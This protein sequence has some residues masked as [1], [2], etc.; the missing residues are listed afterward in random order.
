MLGSRTLSDQST[1]KTRRRLVLFSRNAPT[2]RRQAVHRAPRPP[3]IPAPAGAPTC[4]NA[5]RVRMPRRL[6][7]KNF[8]R[9]A[10]HGSILAPRSDSAEA[11]LQNKRNRPTIAING[12]VFSRRLSR[13]PFACPRRQVE[14]PNGAVNLASTRSPKPSKLCFRRLD[15]CFESAPSGA[16]AP[17]LKTRLQPIPFLLNQLKARDIQ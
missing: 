12:R 13:R 1:K 11:P 6:L 2:C 5:K 14:Q 8:K 10:D 16:I 3:P 4:D 9:L 15:D 17:R 7:A